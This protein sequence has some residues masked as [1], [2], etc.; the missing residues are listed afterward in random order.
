MK[1]RE[2][3]LLRGKRKEKTILFSREQAIIRGR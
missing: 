1:P 3:R 2:E